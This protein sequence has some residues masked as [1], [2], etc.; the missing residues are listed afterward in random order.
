M[1]ITEIL[2][3]PG[4]RLRYEARGNDPD[5][6]STPELR[7]DDS[8]P[9]W[10]LWVPRR[11]TC[12]GAAVARLPGLRWLPG[13]PDARAAA[14]PVTVTKRRRVMAAARSPSAGVRTWLDDLG[15]VGRPACP[16][17]GGCDS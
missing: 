17:M 14:A 12:S 16:L 6:D 11:P 15:T 3:V 8:A 9:C 13:I 10:M 7:A 5:Q 4:A 1:T 2:D